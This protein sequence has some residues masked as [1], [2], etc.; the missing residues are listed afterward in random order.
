MLVGVSVYTYA[1]GSV[2]TIVANLDARAAVLSNKLEVFQNYAS[3]IELPAES[4][5]RVQRFLENDARDMHNLVEQEQLQMELPPSLRIEV[6]AFTHSEVVNKIVFFQNKTQDFLRKIL[7]DL[8]ARKVYSG[9]FLYSQGDVA[10]EIYF[11][12]NGAFTLYV[13]VSEM[14][15][16]PENTI[17]RTN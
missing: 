17:D 12:L 14:L 3:R 7:P 2:S 16:W 13:D 10:D 5:L 6:V 4:S 8:R 1:V 11:V 15:E 9:D